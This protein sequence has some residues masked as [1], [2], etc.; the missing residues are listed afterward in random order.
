MGLLDKI[1]TMV[2]KEEVQDNE[3]I[4]PNALPSPADLDEPPFSFRAAVH[5]IRKGDVTS[6]VKHL[7]H[8]KRY[9]HCQD[10][11]DN[12]LL[13]QAALY[14]QPAALK[15]LVEAGADLTLRYKDKTP[16]HLVVSTDS[17]WVQANKKTDFAQHRMEQ[18][19]CVKLLLAA[20]AELDPIDDAGETPLHTAVRMG[21]AD[22]AQLLLEQGASVDILTGCG[23]VEGQHTEGRTPLLL[24]AR[25]SK[26]KRVIEFL[27]EKGAN[28]NA[29]DKEPG[30]TPLHYIA[31]APH[32]TEKKAEQLLGAIA[33]ILLKHK[34]DPNIRSLKKGNQAPI[35]LAAARNHVAVA[36]ALLNHG[37]EINSKAAKDMTPMGIAASEGMMDMVECLLR[38]GVDVY[39]SRA[40][41]YAAY[42]KKSTAVME[43]LLKRGVDINH[44]DAHG[45]T[46]IF[47]AVSINS[48]RNVQFLLDH[49]ANIKIHPPGRTLLQHA[50]ANWGAVEAMPDEQKKTQSADA[51]KIIEILGGF[52]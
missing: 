33:E 5:A 40:M 10:W 49:G 50:F 21:Y 25:Y 28:A 11:D 51:R 37:A 9:A 45:V 43:L 15:A 31:F 12:T 26:N 44:P 3:H 20:K 38:H 29:Q 41:F 16:L 46:P 34:A 18:R 39:E 27:L 23:A 7:T 30:F 32:Q 8:E 24:A 35:H 48:Y 19:E 1:K 14:A 17:M 42:C 36:E 13:H 4:D 6:L 2:A 47:A 52:D 22:L